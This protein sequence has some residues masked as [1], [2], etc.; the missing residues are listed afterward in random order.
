MRLKFF[1]GAERV[2]RQT[3]LPV[4]LVGGLKSLP[5]SEGVLQTG[6]VDFISLARSLIRQPDLPNLWLSGQGPGKA[7][8]ISCN[9]CIAAGETL[10][11]CKQLEA[12]PKTT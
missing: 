8:C 7:A 1:P 3:G 5:K 6:M 9:A 11:G 10:L 12:K 2:K 4:L